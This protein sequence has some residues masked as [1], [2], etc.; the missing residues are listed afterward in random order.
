MFL[1]HIALQLFCDYSLSYMQLYFARE[2]CF[3]ILHYYYYYYYYYCF[4]CCSSC[5]C[6]VVVVERTEIA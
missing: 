2:I 1:G 6:F 5:S 3:V 4:S